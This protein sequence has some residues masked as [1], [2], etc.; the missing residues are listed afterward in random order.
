[1]LP[2]VDQAWT[3]SIHV[4]PSFQKAVA[5]PP[6]LKPQFRWIL[7]PIN[8]E[9]RK[10]FWEKT[11]WLPRQQGARFVGR[12]PELSFWPSC[13]LPCTMIVTAE[14]KREIKFQWASATA[15]AT[16]LWPNGGQQTRDSIPKVQ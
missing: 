12:P 9:R 4:R 1:M 10:W 3:M 2:H 14:V 7:S 13:F 6:A 5:R 8:P 16:R 15:T 11:A